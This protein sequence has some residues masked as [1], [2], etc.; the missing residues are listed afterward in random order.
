MCRL[1]LMCGCFGSDLLS[2]VSSSRVGPLG[3]V[4][5]Q[6]GVVCLLVPWSQISDPL[7]DSSAAPPAALILQPSASQELSVLTEP[8]C[9][10]SWPCLSLLRLLLLIC[11]LV[12]ISPQPPSLY[13]WLSIYFFGLSSVYRVITAYLSVSLWSPACTWQTT[14]ST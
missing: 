12:V 1:F 13:I 9:L 7:L 6:P 3:T 4:W 8:V 14:T 2:A 5:N 10:S 11:L